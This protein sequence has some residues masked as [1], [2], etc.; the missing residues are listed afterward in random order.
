MRGGDEQTGAMFSYL[1]P[2]ALVPSGHPLRA[3][4]VLVNRALERLSP[5]FGKLYAPGGRASI[6]PEKL[7]RA[8]LLQAFFGVRSERQLM[9]QIAYN[10]LFR[11]FI[12]MSMDAPVWDVTVFTK[13]RQR[14]LDG[15]I[16]R[17]FLLTVMADNEVTH[18]L[19]DEHFSVDGTLIQAW[20]SLKSFQPKD[21][22]GAPPGP[23]RNAERDFHG[24]K[25]SNA[26]H[27]S[28]TDPDARLFRKGD[29]QPARLCYMGHLLIENRHGLIVDAELTLATGWAERAAAEAM[30]DDTAAGRRVTLAADKGY[31]TAGHVAR[32]RASGVTP[33]VAQHTN[34]RRSAIDGRTTR[35]PGY[36]ISQR[37]RK[38]IEE[39]FGWMKL[40]A[41][42]RQTKH[43]GRDRVGWMFDLKAAACNLIRLPMLLAST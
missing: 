28:T 26:T 12:G 1:S 10:M 14:L 41:G 24:E 19:S 40:A 32:L 2:E 29:G 25:R 30:I 17:E 42:F 16:A 36:A 37:F 11:W 6:A 5:E 27:A 38:R 22:S 21:G 39:P 31:D 9:E 4:R 35:H 3:I 8:L 18:L 43:R 20:A 13:N 23:G 7:L 34:G 15:D 33:H